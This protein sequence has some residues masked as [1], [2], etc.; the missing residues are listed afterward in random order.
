[1]T[2]E[3]TTKPSKSVAFTFGEP[4]AA[5]GS[6]DTIGYLHSY[7]NGEY[8]NPPISMNGLAK[9]LNANPHHASAIE[10]KR[11]I[12][13]SCFIP[14]K[15]LSADDFLKLA[16]DYMVFGNCYLER[17]NDRAG[18]ALK[19]KHS[20][21]KFT[22]KTQAGYGFLKQGHELHHFKPDHVWHIMNPD[23]NQEYYGIP[24]YMSALQSVFL[25]ESATLFRRRYYEN[26]SHAGYILYIND[27]AQ[28]EADIDNIR[29]SLKESKGVGNFKNLFMYAP[30]G[31]K[32]GVQLIPISEVAA[33]DEFLDIK[34]VTRDDILAAH[35]VPPVIMG[36]MPNNVGGF[37]SV[38]AASKVFA[39]NEIMPLQ[40]RFTAINDWA[41][42]EA[43]KFNH[44]EIDVADAGARVR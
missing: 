41:G 24:S 31:K 6:R 35:R 3:K 39:R 14:S 43:V 7:W 2:T 22:M 19:L 8:Y 5:L 30:D 20:P 38:E 17:I 27:A 36:I 23:I 25:N 29:N 33:K 28:S 16:Q 10:C 18:R 15:Y 26:G 42:V 44:Y 32:D 4:E 1:M 40:S 37:G 21:A 12:L 9:T 34:N 13:A 11:N